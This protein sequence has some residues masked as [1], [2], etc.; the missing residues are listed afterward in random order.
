V[1]KV[2]GKVLPSGVSPNIAYVL[3]DQY[4]GEDHLQPV[5]K[6]TV[7]ELMDAIGGKELVQFVSEEYA[8]H[9]SEVFD[10]LGVARLTM[11]NVWVVF[12]DMLPIMHL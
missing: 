6:I 5:D 8:S 7:Q 2:N 12:E 10:S 11:Q 4:G 3:P 9:A 1:G